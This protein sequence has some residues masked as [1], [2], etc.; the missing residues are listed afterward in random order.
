[1]NHVLKQ[2]VNWKEQKL[3]QLIK[4]I[5]SV[6]ERQQSEVE[7][8]VIGRGQWKFSNDYA[9][10]VFSEMTWFSNMS[11][12]AK[13]KHMKKVFNKEIVIAQNRDS[14]GELLDIS[15]LDCNITAVPTVTLCNIWG[16]AKDLVKT[17]A[18]IKIPWIKDE[19]SRLVKSSSSDQPHLVNMSNMLYKCDDKCP[20]FKGYSRCSHV[21]A[22]AQ[23]NGDLRS[24]VDCYNS[25]DLGPNLSSIGYADLPSG[26]GRKGGVPKRKRKSRPSVESLSVRPCFQSSSMTASPQCSTPTVSSSQLP[27]QGLSTSFSIPNPLNITS[28]HL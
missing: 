17:N 19:K 16:K 9:D 13:K 21:I 3:P 28:S 23:V 2:E 15:Y 6:I 10:L 24:F 27:H 14:C 26:A 4:H 1:M 11:P 25:K 20:M 8:A 18:V 5:K 22:T 7:M 12:D